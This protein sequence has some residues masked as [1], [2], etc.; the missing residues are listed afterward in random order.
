[1]KIVF[2]VIAATFTLFSHSLFLK[3]SYVKTSSESALFSWS[4]QEPW[5]SASYDRRVTTLVLCN[6]ERGHDPRI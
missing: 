5:V 1:M 2:M 6:R 4:S 3:K